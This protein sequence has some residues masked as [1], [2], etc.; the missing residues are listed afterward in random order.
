MAGRGD[1]VTS[2]RGSV[3]RPQGGSKALLPTPEPEPIADRLRAAEGSASRGSQ[4]PSEGMKASAGLHHAAPAAP[5]AALG[6]SSPL[7]FTPAPSV[8][9]GT[10]SKPGPALSIFVRGLPAPQGSMTTRRGG[11]TDK[12]GKYHGAKLKASNEAELE[13]W[14][15]QVWTQCFAAWAGRPKIV[16]R[17][18]AVDLTF[19]VM[20]SR[21][22]EPWML[23]PETGLYRLA[24]MPDLDKLARAV[25]DGITFGKVWADDKLCTDLSARA[26]FASPPDVPPGCQI[27]LRVL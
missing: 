1:A 4:E 20:K 17:C 27:E 16:N 13:S 8:L 2:R 14:R 6:A 25:L 15:G 22:R 7:R 5:S 9:E 26:Y 19:Y 3:A 10:L 24:E 11:F 21:G 12:N 18:V 23:D